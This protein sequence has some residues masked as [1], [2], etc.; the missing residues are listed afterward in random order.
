MSDSATEKLLPQTDHSKENDIEQEEDGKGIHGMWEDVDEKY[1]KPLFGGN[2]RIQKSHDE[3][4]SSTTSHSNASN[5]LI[6]HISLTEIAR[7]HD[8]TMTMS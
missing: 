3:S 4:N 7:N 8:A 1:L 6:R 5:R 2:P